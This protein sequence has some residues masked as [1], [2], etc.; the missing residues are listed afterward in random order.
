M[1]RRDDFDGTR[2]VM[3]HTHRYATDSIDPRSICCLPIRFVKD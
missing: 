2:R 3:H 1:H